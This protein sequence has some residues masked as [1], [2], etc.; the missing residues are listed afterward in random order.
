M[1][2]VDYTPVERKH[3]YHEI[4]DQLE[5]M[6][7]DESLK[8]GDKLPPEQKLAKRLGVSRNV[9]R[10]AIKGLHERGLI[11]VIPGK[12]AYIAKPTSKILT[13]TLNR[14]VV[15]GDITPQQLY[16]I[17]IPLEVVGAGLAAKRASKEQLDKLNN[18][19]RQMPQAAGNVEEWCNI[20]LQF[21]VTIAEASGNPLIQAII[22][23]LA[24]LLL[25]L[26]A[27]GYSKEGEVKMGISKHRQI[28]ETMKNGDKKGAENAMREHLTLSENAVLNQK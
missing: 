3:L 27:A 5:Q 17:R 19:V 21:H 24:G 11:S 12:G 28:Y 14:L 26:F 9:L 16:E 13:E 25:K 7:M 20:D 18:L 23:P 10:E 22:S 1:L 2:M 4:A 15:L 6:I 8:V